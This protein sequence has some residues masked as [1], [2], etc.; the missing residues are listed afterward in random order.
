[1]TQPGSIAFFMGDSEH[2][3]HF[4]GLNHS[5]SAR[6]VPLRCG[7]AH[8]D[9]FLGTVADRRTKPV[10]L[11]ALP[12]VR[13]PRRVRHPPSRDGFEGAWCWEARA[14]R[15][16]RDGRG[17]RGEMWRSKVAS[18][19]ARRSAKGMAPEAAFFLRRFDNA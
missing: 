10:C 16:V 19:T 5:E 11:S 8:L 6:P 7:I 1:M 17:K 15:D 2:K 13:S 4:F 18:S 12:E 3:W 9:T 14:P